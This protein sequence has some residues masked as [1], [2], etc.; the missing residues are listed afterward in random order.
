MGVFVH[1]I[2]TLFSPEFYPESVLPSTL[3]IGIALAVGVGMYRRHWGL[4]PLTTAGCVAMFVLVGVGIRYPVVGP[5]LA[6][7]KWLLL[8][9][10]FL[11]SVLP[12]WLLLQPRDYINS[13]F[14]Y[15]GVGAM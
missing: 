7:W 10:A 11:S 2:A 14:L 6:E 5:S 4:V 1:I 9:Y 3:L 13:L 15:V 8:G 12:V